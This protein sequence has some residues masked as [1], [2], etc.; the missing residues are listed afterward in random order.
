MGDR[1][2]LDA[3]LV[4]DAASLPRVLATPGVAAAAERLEVRGV[5]AFDLGSPLTVV[6]Y[7]REGDVFAGRPLLE[8]RRARTDDEVEVGRGLA[9]ALGLAPGGRLVAE[10]AA[11]GE[12]RLRVV[13]VV[14]ELSA[15]G[16]VAYASLAAVRAAAPDA[17]GAVA[18]RPEAGVSTAELTRRL[19]ARGLRVEAN[20]GLAPA[21]APFVDT[22]VALLR[23]VAAV[24]GLVC[25]AIV[26]LSLVVLARERA[27]TIAILRTCGAR[28]AEVVATLPGAALV[29]LLLAVPLGFALER[30]ALGL[31]LSHVAARYGALPLQPSALELAGVLAGAAAL[32]SLAGRDDGCTAGPGAD[33]RGAPDGVASGARSGRTRLRAGRGARCDRT[34]CR[35]SPLPGRPARRGRRGRGRCRRVPGTPLGRPIAG[36]VDH[37]GLQPDA[38][39]REL[40]QAEGP[41]CLRVVDQATARAPAS[42]RRWPCGAGR[43]RARWV[44]PSRAPRWTPGV[45][46]Q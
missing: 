17:P 24:T 19:E 5:D 6:A 10:L 46:V 15:D 34:G 45:V 8:G 27:E 14:Q 1:R 18:V 31:T 38:S 20:A 39:V 32:A 43:I 40:D 2:A 35:S 13:G 3:L 42:S 23:V 44:S 37:Q 11:G 33:R 28:P 26:L 16:R 7:G 36:V 29:L 22:I 41:Q 30:L 21:G 12:L 9:Q 4:E 25:G